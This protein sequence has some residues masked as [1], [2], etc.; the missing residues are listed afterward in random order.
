MYGRITFV[1]KAIAI[2]LF[3]MRNYKTR[4][5]KTKLLVSLCFIIR[6]SLGSTLYTTNNDIL[7]SQVPEAAFVSCEKD[8]DFAWCLPKGYQKEL[9]PWNYRE[10]TNS[11]LPWFYF[12]G[13]GIVDIHRVDD[14]AQTVTLEMFFKIKWYEPRIVVNTTSLKWNQQATKVDGEEY[15]GI[16]ISQMK[17][18]WI[19]DV[20]IRRLKKYIRK[21]VLTPA[22]SFRTNGN[23]L[24]RYVARVELILSCQMNFRNYPFDS[25]VCTSQQGSFYNTKDIVDCNAT[26][27]REEEKQRSLQYTLEILDLP[28]KYYTTESQGAFWATCGFQMSLKRKKTQILCEVYLTS[29]LLVVVSWV[30]FIINPTVVPGRLGLLVTVFLVLINI[31][32][33]AKKNAPPSSGFLHA[34]DIFLLVCVGHVFLAILEYAIILLR[35]FRKQDTIFEPKPISSHPTE[36]RQVYPESSMQIFS[37]SNNNSPR[38]LA[39][40]MKENRNSYPFEVE[41]KTLDLISLLIFPFSFTTFIA[42]YF[43]F[44]IN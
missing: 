30:S 24:L 5:N 19:P 15:V 11:N 41:N 28:L 32:I 36:L 42:I 17:T 1:Q 44:Y 4:F 16:P 43:S 10:L 18:F 29:S 27:Y 25:H 8:N 34:L 12:F 26:W 23:R 7:D 3:S 6:I 35:N 21:E 40:W 13:F 38:C 20:E 22:A 14:H 2:I 39:G 31:F 9:A 37:K 33:G